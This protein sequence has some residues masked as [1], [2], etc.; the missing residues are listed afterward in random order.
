MKQ[1][2]KA[3][4]PMLLMI[5]VTFTGIGTGQTVLALPGLLCAVP[6]AIFWAGYVVGRQGGGFRSPIVFTDRPAAK[7][8]STQ[9]EQRIIE[10]YHL[11]KKKSATNK[12]K[13]EFND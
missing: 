6:L 5:A 4:M 11:Q 8:I 12:V 13:A 9:D 3:F 7:P 2:L 1:L 10:R